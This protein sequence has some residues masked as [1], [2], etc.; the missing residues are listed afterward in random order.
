MRKTPWIAAV[1]VAFALLLGG[2]AAP[3]DP[4]L[5]VSAS[6]WPRSD[7]WQ[8]AADAENYLAGVYAVAD[9]MLPACGTW[10]PAAE[11]MHKAHAT[12]LTQPDP[13]GGFMASSTHVLP[14]FGDEAT[15]E[16]ALKQ[17]AQDCLT[18][19]EAGLAAAQ[20]GPEALLW[21]SLAAAASVSLAWADDPSVARPAPVQGDVV[22]SRIDVSA[23]D[24]ANAV[25]GGV[26]GLI[27]AM[28]VASA[29]PTTGKDMLVQLTA[30]LADAQSQRS[31]LQAQIRAAGGIPS[32]PALAY[33]LSNG[34][35]DDAAI[36][37]SLNTFELALAIPYIRLAGTQT[38]DTAVATLTRAD[39]A[40]ATAAGQ[41]ITWW[42]GWG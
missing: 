35:G 2:C 3:G 34:V 23:A 41:T 26:D 28:T 6:P 19:D 39:L 27:Y 16:K 17:A 38:G 32:A 30:Q 14:E 21:A 22:P 8:K 13:F 11:A 31:A 12:V 37:A 29:Q 7:L 20:P 5:E 40:G 36:A 24:A 9:T 33:P 42:P 15:L 18:A 25:L 10:C 1:C 4:R